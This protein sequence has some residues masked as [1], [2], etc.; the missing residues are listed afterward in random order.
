M[1]LYKNDDDEDPREKEDVKYKGLIET[2]TRIKQSLGSQQVALSNL[3]MRVNN[4][5]ERKN[6]QEEMRLNTKSQNG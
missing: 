4:L 5:I 6:K 1:K 3:V 2:M